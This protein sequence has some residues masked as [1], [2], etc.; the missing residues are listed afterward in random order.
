MNDDDRMPLLVRL[1]E[2]EFLL[3]GGVWWQDAARRNRLPQHISRLRE[4]YHAQRRPLPS[5]IEST[6]PR[7]AIA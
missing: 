5:Q 6:Q 7:K 2:F 3:A 1:D 4:L